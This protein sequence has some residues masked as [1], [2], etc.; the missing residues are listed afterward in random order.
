MAVE[1][2]EVV[3]AKTAEMGEAADPTTPARTKVRAKVARVVKVV[4]EPP[5][6]VPDTQ[7]GPQIQPAGCITAGGS[8]VTFVLNPSHVRGRIILLQ[9]LQATNETLTS[10]TELY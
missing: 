9:N 2:G 7:M 10:S 8:R 5:G 3:V 1:A 6:E 4:K